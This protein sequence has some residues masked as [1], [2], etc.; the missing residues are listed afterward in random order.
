MTLKPGA[1]ASVLLLLC[2]IGTFARP[3]SHRYVTV[4]IGDNECNVDDYNAKGDGK[5]DDT[6]VT[7]DECSTAF[8]EHR[9]GENELHVADIHILLA[10][11]PGCNQP[12]RLEGWRPRDAR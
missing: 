8:S 11:N 4:E 3:L 5:T 6:A 2:V 7:C 1:S 12:L 9:K 10:G